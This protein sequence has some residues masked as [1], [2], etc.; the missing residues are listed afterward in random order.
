MSGP[1]ET[2]LAELGA[3]LPDAPAPAANYVPFVQTG[4]TL[5]V[6]G[7]IS[8]DAEGQ[9]ITGKLGETMTTEQGAAAAKRCALSLLAQ[10]KAACGGDIEKLVRVVKL[11]GFVNSTADF[12]EQPQV[13]KRRVGF[14][15]GSAGRGRPPFPLRRL[16]CRAAA[17]RRRRDRRDLP[18]HVTPLPTSFAARP[19]AHRALHGPGR[20]ENA[21]AAILA[22]V[23]AGYGIEIDLQLSSDGAAMVFHDET[24]DRL[25]AETGP[26]RARRA[27]DLQQIRLTGGDDRIPTFAE[28]LGMVAGH[29]PLL[30]EVKDQSGTL[31]E[32]DGALERAAASDVS[33]YVGPLAFMSFNPHM[34][35]HLADLAPDIHVD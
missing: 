13:I 10:V 31:G 26:V 25:T 8:L 18:G 19:I 24:L 6:S 28:V 33:G 1:I 30:V 17:G 32:S 20:P 27:A 23:E 15:R 21:R 16:G 4:D 14:P 2:R 34:V 12:T 5:Y 11:T 29:V 35:A 7:Q 22:A 3:T 9:L